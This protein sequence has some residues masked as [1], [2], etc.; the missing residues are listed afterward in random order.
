MVQW[1]FRALLLPLSS[2]FTKNIPTSHQRSHNFH[3]NLL[4]H[5]I[6]L[7]FCGCD[8]NSKTDRKETVFPLKRYKIESRLVSSGVSQLKKIN[9]QQNQWV[10][11]PMEWPLR[12]RLWSFPWLEILTPGLADSTSSRDYDLCPTAPP[13]SS[14]IPPRS[15]PRSRSN[16]FAKIGPKECLEA[17]STNAMLEKLVF[18]PPHIF[19]V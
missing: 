18:S 10:I 14:P 15:Y 7:A 3:H 5:K 4:K 17:L 12:G 11:R 9:K 1:H 13:I 6:S 8:L 19:E 2:S 16:P